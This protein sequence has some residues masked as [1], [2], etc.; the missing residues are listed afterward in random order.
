[1]TLTAQ[2]AA[3]L[4]WGV[5]DARR[6]YGR[7]HGWWD[8][9]TAV[10]EPYWDVPRRRITVDEFDE[11]L[12]QR[13]EEDWATS[14]HRWEILQRICN[15]L[16]RA[17]IDTI[18]PM[19]GATYGIDETTLM[20]AAP[21][22][23]LGTQPGKKRSAMPAASYFTRDRGV[24]VEHADGTKSRGGDKRG[25]GVGVTA[26]SRFGPR[27]NLVAAAPVYVAVEFG[28]VTSGDPA[29]ALGAIDRAQAAGL[30]LPGSKGRRP[31]LLAIDMGYSI[32]R[33][34]NDGLLRRGYSASFHY[35]EG[36]QGVS[37]SPS[38]LSPSRGR[39]DTGPVHAW[40]GHFCPA[41]AHLLGENL[42]ART[43]D[44]KTTEHWDRHDA[45]LRQILPARMG[46]NG[47]PKIRRCGTG[48]PVTGIDAPTELRQTL[49]CPAVQGRVQ[50]PLKPDSMRS[51]A[52]GDRQPDG[53]PWGPEM[54]P[55][56]E[57]DR[58]LCCRNSQVTVPMTE[59][60]V[61]NHQPGLQAGSWEHIFFLEAARALTE[62]RF[63]DL[64]SAHVGGLAS[65][66]TGPR[67]TAMVYLAITMAMAATNRRSQDSHLAW[68]RE[69]KNR[70]PDLRRR[71]G[72]PPME[73]PPLT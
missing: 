20:A 29:R 6:E 40:G 8:R 67:S 15:L 72:R 73:S 57:A 11:I 10:L 51:L 41:V 65:V 61:R 58:Y 68:P 3:D 46:V 26:L 63:A 5:I 7:F 71:L 70:W 23:D 18:T 43:D 31:P 52:D 1:M 54:R 38:V 44:M 21:D 64:K 36:W 56:W 53:R 24:V 50:C 59:R 30:A 55:T 48:R 33:G 25:V 4:R 14:R 39:E 62:Q 32:K 34:F 47:R 60:Q 19:P 22:R 69:A 28:L 37:M 9:I 2:Q 35:R 49:I 16:I 13:S 17:S 45:R 12:E 27:H 66:Q 42:V